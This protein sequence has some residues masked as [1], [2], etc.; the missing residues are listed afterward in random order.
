MLSSSGPLTFLRDL[1]YQEVLLRR[2]LFLCNHAV[3]WTVSMSG[4]CAGPWCLVALAW[5][6]HETGQ[7]LNEVFGHSRQAHCTHH[8]AELNQKLWIFTGKNSCVGIG[9]EQS[10]EIFLFSKWA[11]AVNLLC[12]SLRASA[13][14]PVV[15]AG[16]NSIRQDVPCM[17]FP[18]CI[19]AIW[20]CFWQHW[21]WVAMSLLN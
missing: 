7:A 6:S 17:L 10:L 21:Q 1:G 14:W 20:E 4:T 2:G 9:V 19:S 11:A 3:K 8:A 15:A 12:K 18:K 5:L 13:E 16:T